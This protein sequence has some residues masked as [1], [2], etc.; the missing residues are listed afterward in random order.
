MLFI[1]LLTAALLPA[2]VVQAAPSSEEFDLEG[3]TSPS[4][5]SYMYYDTKKKS[6]KHKYMSKP[7]C[8]MKKYPYCAHGKK[9]WSYYGT[10]PPTERL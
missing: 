2:A 7:K 4:C 8:P 10:P 5:P 3:R 1:N 6:C 9:D